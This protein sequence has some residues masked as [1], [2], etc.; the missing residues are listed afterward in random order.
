ME[1]TTFSAVH[2]MFHSAREYL[3][4]LLRNSKFRDTGVLTP[5]EFVAAGD[6]LVFKCPTWAWVAGDP[7][8]A[9]DFLPPDKQYLVTRNAME[10]TD[11]DVEGLLDLGSLGAAGGAADGAHRCLERRRSVGHDAP[12]P[13]VAAARRH[14]RHGRRRRA[15]RPGR[16]PRQGLHRVRC[17]GP[18]CVGGRRRQRGS[19]HPGPD[20]Q[21][22]Q[23]PHI[24]HV[25]HVRQ[26]LPDPAPP[27]AADSTQVFQDISQDHAQKTVT[28]EAHP[29][30]NVT[31]A[32]IHP[33]KH[34]NVMKRILDQMSESGDQTKELRVDQ[35][36]MLFLKFMSA[37]LPTL[38]Y[39]CKLSVALRHRLH[40]DVVLTRIAFYTTSMDT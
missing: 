19:G 36:L 8:K 18:G 25:H 24:R 17:C 35:Y 2:A 5:D 38:E 9:R 23:N 3:N 34:A 14:C 4:P 15:G 12:G 13:L 26:V 16:R 22:P 29:H 40:L 20:R 31:L 10:Y 32:S 1:R 6:F 7:A 11:D 37:V 28:I 39:D 33:C 21:D 30:E 27:S